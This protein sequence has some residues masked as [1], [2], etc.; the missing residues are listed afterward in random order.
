MNRRHLLQAPLALLPLLA[1]SRPAHAVP[2]TAAD[3]A[4]LQRIQVYLNSFRTLRAH[5]VQEAPDGTL[6]AG[7]AWLERPGRMRFQ[8]DPPSPLLL[9]ADDGEVV[10]HDA[11]LD[12]TSRIPL[13]RT[14]LS[15]VLADQV[16]LSGAATVTDIQRLPNEIQISLVL[17]AQPGQ[18]L[19]ALVF[20]DNPLALRQWTVVDAQHKITRVSLDGIVFGG[21]FDEALFKFPK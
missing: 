9:V 10:F 18:G 12:Q 4:D 1:L 8:Y 13:G 20:A 7:T 11:Q 21:Q 5:F 16:R 15:I 17:T 19:L 14:P 2:P 6:S 3:R